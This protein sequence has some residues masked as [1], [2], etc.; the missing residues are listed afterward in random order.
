V[1]AVI[2]MYRAKA[3]GLAPASG[4]S[5]KQRRR[6]NSTAQGNTQRNIGKP[7]HERRELRG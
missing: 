1:Q 3:E 7:R 4:K 6:V 2:H 5:R